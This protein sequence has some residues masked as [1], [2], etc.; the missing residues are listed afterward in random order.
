MGL[1]D[2]GKFVFLGMHE[3]H[4]SGSVKHLVPGLC[5]CIG[6][7]LHMDFTY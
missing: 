2:L 5:M 7:D 3:I 6:F 1:C 4:T